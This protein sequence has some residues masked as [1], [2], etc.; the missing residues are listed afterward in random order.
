MAADEVLFNSR[1]KPSPGCR[2]NR[3]TEPFLGIMPNLPPARQLG[4]ATAYRVW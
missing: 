1:W 3:N 2:E 4:F